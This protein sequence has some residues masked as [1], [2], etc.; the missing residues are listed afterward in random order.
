[1]QH[2]ISLLRRIAG[3]LSPR[4]PHFSLRRRWIWRLMSQV[5]P[6]LSCYS[7]A[8]TWKLYLSTRITAGGALAGS[9]CERP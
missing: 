7:M 8:I 9:S 4:S 3:I 5:V 1:M 6:L 2:I